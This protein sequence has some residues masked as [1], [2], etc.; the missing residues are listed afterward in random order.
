MKNI[1]I[2]IISSISILF[3]ACAENNFQSNSFIGYVKPMKYTSDKN[4]SIKKGGNFLSVSNP[5]VFNLNEN[6]TDTFKEGECIVIDLI[7][8]Y[9]NQSFENIKKST[10]KNEIVLTTSI[11]ERT[12]SSS[13]KNKNSNTEYNVFPMNGQLSKRPLR[14]ENIPIYGP[15]KYNGGDIIFQILMSEKD[16]KE[17]K[18]IENNITRGTDKLIKALPKDE[19]KSTLYSTVGKI[20]SG[21][22][23]S[24]SGAGI[25]AVGLDAVKTFTKI[26]SK[27]NGKDDKII[28]HIFS[29]TSAYRTNN[30]YSPTLRVGY[31]PLIRISTKTDISDGLRNAKFNPIRS[32]LQIENKNNIK[33]EPIWLA[34]RISKTRN[35]TR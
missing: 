3:C 9:L 31:Y 5:N 13:N 28:Q 24:L 26:Y 17:W 27:I 12:Y 25:V 22:T 10:T 33:E 35:C 16:S 30:I 32:E 14:I 8:G 6:N 20:L 29:L 11:S 7:G 15:R 18:N 2:L 23:L 34:F 4:L 21:S 1:N 19:E